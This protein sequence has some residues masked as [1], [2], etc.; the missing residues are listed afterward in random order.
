MKRR[1]GNLLAGWCTLNRSTRLVVHDVGGA[2]DDGAS[3][4]DIGEAGL[5]ASIFRGMPLGMVEIKVVEKGITAMRPE[6]TAESGNSTRS[7]YRCIYPTVV[8]GTNT[9]SS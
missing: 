4:V 2:V 7:L 3:E 8:G 6:R 1:A 5:Q 9:G